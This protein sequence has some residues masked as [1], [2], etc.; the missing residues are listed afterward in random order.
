M[1]KNSAIALISASLLAAAPRAA[2]AGD[3]EGFDPKVKTYFENHCM[4][5]HDADS[6]KGDFRLDRLSNKVGFEDT[7]QWLEVMSRITSGEMPP[8]K[9]KV[10]PSA[11]DS[12]LVVEWL[13]ARMREGESARL[14]ARGR[15]SYNRLTRDEYVNT[16]RDLLGV[17]FDAT[18]PGGFL[19]D[20]EWRG[21]ERIGSVMTLSPSNIEKYLAA[22]ETVLAEAYPKE[23][24]K[25]MDYLKPAIEERQ[26]AENHREDLRARGLLDKVR[27][28]MWPGDIYRYAAP[29]DPLPEAGIYEVTIKLSGLKPATGPAPH[30]FVYETK[31]D[32]VL[33]E[34][35]VL[36]DEDKPITIT[37]QTHLP[38]G[39]PSIDVINNV[40]GPKNTPPSGRHGQK[41]FISTKDGRSPWQVKL[42]DEQGRPRYP[43]L[44]LDS[45]QWRGPLI[46]EE[47]QIRRAEYLPQH[48]G[49]MDEARECLGKLA[50]RAYR[51]PLRDGELDVYMGIVKEELAAKEKFTDAVKA[52]M[53]AILCSKSFLFITEGDE[54]KMRTTINDWE[55]ASRLSYLL[56]NTMPDDTLFALAEQG[57]LHDKAELRRQVARLLADARSRRFTDAFA[58]QWL[59]LK[60]VGKFPPDKKLYPD[61]DA[62]LERSMIGETKAFVSEVLTHDL[63][64]REF[65]SSDWTMLNERLSDYYGLREA[66]LPRND[67]VR[68][69][70]PADSK[71]GG[72]LTQASILSLTSDGTRHRPVHR[73]VWVSEAIFGRVPP[74][75][76][77][78][79][80][81]IPTNPVGA[82]K[83]TLR[84]KLDAHIHDAKCAACHG[85]IDPLGLAFE[86]F[87]AIGR[88]RTAEKV[89]GGV[90]DD[91]PVDPSGKLPDGREYKTAEE[92]K[93]LILADIDKFNAT[94]IEK[95]A[96][97]GLRRTT[98]FGDQEGLAEV[99][100]V[101]R[102][103]DYRLKDIIE[104]FVVSDLFERR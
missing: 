65:I 81:P 54:E 15:V 64:L 99:A 93:K 95:L 89:E 13:S 96:T 6:E 61:Y 35:D 43:F 37:F 3:F 51:R 28:E 17:H 82:P 23:K 91:P 84:M 47:E 50:R 30:L 7:N 46:T 29:H 85:K 27:F 103:K 94:F 87:D 25:F 49:N 90:G 52:G 40:P 42:T 77:P 5:C 14:A 21:F 75:P 53:A 98:S 24:P 104:A 78:N 9:E 100:K 45:V 71:R 86:N 12:A 66:N 10:R 68:V 39:R 88:W 59:H 73:G 41:P 83:A 8:K 79:V 32:R 22:A 62:Q 72:L 102:E 4:S 18:D 97:Y 63:T 101:S 57:K 55:I 48:E 11:Q 67:F 56:W 33:W 74:P 1:L 69:S 44:I 19:E 2:R 20:A 34:Q 16:V 80:D 76:P 92:F 26:I 38:K 36:A 31:L 60:K 70:L 58:T